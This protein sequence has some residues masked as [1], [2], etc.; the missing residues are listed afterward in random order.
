TEFK[1]KKVS[2]FQ[3]LSER[4]VNTL[5]RQLNKSSIKCTISTLRSLLNSDFIKEVNPF[6]EYFNAVSKQSI[7]KID[8]IDQL[9]QTVIAENDTFWK[10]AFKKWLVNLVACALEG[11]ETVRKL[12]IRSG[13]NQQVLVF[14]GQQGIG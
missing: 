7:G 8:Y 12:K 5:F 3:L 9:A 11:T 13:I 1:R 6:E 14:V 4:D 10:W 2:N